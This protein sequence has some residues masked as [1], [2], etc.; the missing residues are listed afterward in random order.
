[1]NLAPLVYERCV[2]ATRALPRSMPDGHQLRAAG[3]VFARADADTVIPRNHQHLKERAPRHT[4]DRGDHS[5]CQGSA[6]DLS[7]DGLVGYL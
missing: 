7:A 3:V 4:A 6:L 2:M 1:M 5:A